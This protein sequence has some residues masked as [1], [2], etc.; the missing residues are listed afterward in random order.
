MSKSTKARVFVPLMKVDEEQRLVFGKITAQ[1]VDQSG[2]MMDYDTSKPNFESWSLR[3][4]GLG[5]SL[6]GQ[7]SRH[8]RSICG[9]QADRHQL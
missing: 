3:S 2:E 9:R 7:P 6:E 5:W 4:S 8:A 1:E